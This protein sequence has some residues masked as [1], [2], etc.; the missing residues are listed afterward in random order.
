MSKP[1]GS[2]QSQPRLAEASGRER[3]RPD[4]GPA[5]S[6]GP[7]VGP[8][9]VSGTSRPVSGTFDV[10]AEKLLGGAARLG[11]WGLSPAE[12]ARSCAAPR[13][14]LL[15]RKERKGEKK[16]INEKKKERREEGG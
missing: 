14:P 13:A 11:L 3:G 5:S 9:G 1:E 2:S 16:E 8:E 6:S 4:H 15:S 12:H 7:K 10:W